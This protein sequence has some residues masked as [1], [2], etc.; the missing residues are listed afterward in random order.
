MRLGV[1]ALC[2]ARR[3]RI[4]PRG[5]GDGSRLNRRCRRFD[6]THAGMFSRGGIAVVYRIHQGELVLV[7]ACRLMASLLNGGVGLSGCHLRRKPDVRR[8]VV[9]QKDK[10]WCFRY[11]PFMTTSLTVGPLFGINDVL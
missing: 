10:L 11:S 1:D 4:F 8:P 3:T 9:A 7:A 6:R 5:L 2:S